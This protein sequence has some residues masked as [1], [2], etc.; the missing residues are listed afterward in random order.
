MLCEVAVGARALGAQVSPAGQIRR[1]RAYMR[2]VYGGAPAP[3]DYSAGG[4]LP[5]HQA[6]DFCEDDEPAEKIIAAFERG[7]KGVTAPG[8]GLVRHETQGSEG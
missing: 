2:R 5:A 1:C 3:F 7:G 8:P 6:G 4:G